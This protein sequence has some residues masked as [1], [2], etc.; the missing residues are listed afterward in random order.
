M[1]REERNKLKDIERKE[2]LIEIFNCF[3]SLNGDLTAISMKFDM[4]KSTVSL[5]LRSNLIYELIA[6]GKLTS[7]D[8]QKI[9]DKL[10]ENKQAGNKKGGEVYKEKYEP[11]FDESHRIVGRRRK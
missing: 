2:K 6:E 7:E 10:L 1:T 5:L 3:D 9:K 4:S 11:V 8:Y